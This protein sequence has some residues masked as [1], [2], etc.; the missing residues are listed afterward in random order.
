MFNLNLLQDEAL[1]DIPETVGS[2][3]FVKIALR[4]WYE[5]LA[6]ALLRKSTL[7]MPPSTYSAEDAELMRCY[8]QDIAD[9]LVSQLIYLFNLGITY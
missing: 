9:I 7:L 8:R 3:C 5:Q 2:G 4:G 1:R 6:N